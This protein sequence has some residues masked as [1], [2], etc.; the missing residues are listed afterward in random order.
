MKSISIAVLNHTLD[1]INN[2]SKFSA[3]PLLKKSLKNKFMR[4]L[5]FLSTDEYVGD[6]YIF[7]KYDDIRI[8]AFRKDA[9]F[10]V[11]F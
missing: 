5:Y 2:I 6:F 4:A 11:Y 3:I 1:F 10:I 7:V 9:F 8:F